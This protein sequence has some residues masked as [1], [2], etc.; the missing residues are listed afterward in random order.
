M[1]P[2]FCSQMQRD[3]L[4]SI[5]IY[6][7]FLLYKNVQSGFHLPLSRDTMTETMR[8]IKHILLTYC[9]I[10]VV[11]A[12]LRN[13]PTWDIYEY[14]LCLQSTIKMPAGRNHT[15]P[16]YQHHISAPYCMSASQLCQSWAEYQERSNFYMLA[17][18]C[19]FKPTPHLC[20]LS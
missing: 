2:S 20:P 7:T 13:L 19:G 17:S 4:I 8:H 9:V 15:V 1:M 12:A 14:N 3:I 5:Y 18:K 11:L 16:P 10:Q 6:I